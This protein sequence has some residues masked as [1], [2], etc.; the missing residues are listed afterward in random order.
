MRL[1][2]TAIALLPSA[3]TA[4]AQ[5]NTFTCSSDDGK[6]H[7]CSAPGNG[8]IQMLRQRSQSPCVPGRTYG[9]YRGG[10]WVDNGCR[11]DF[12]VNYAYN[13]PPNGNGYPA[14]GGY[15]GAGSIRYY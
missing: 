7:T 11:A 6:R 5:S 13:R 9:I 2:G 1:A 10:V 4:M 14:G 3:L 15:V 8:A 12:A